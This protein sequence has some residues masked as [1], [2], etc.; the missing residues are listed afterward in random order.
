MYDFFV[1]LA[2]FL[3]TVAQ[4]GKLITRQQPADAVGRS[5]VQLRS[6]RQHEAIF[7]CARADAVDETVE[8]TARG[9]NIARLILA[10]ES[11]RARRLHVC[12]ETFS[13]RSGALLT[14]S[15]PAHQPFVG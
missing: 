3:V 5:I 1:L 2:H 9:K 15:R 13:E 6:E 11:D 12:S 8:D 14:M 4:L 7:R 10:G